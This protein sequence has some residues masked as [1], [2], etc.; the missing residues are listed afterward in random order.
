MR[1]IARSDIVAV[2]LR[3]LLLLHLSDSLS[4]NR[5]T[6][7]ALAKALL[8]VPERSESIFETISPVY[9]GF[10][11]VWVCQ[12]NLVLSDLPSSSSSYKPCSVRLAG[13]QLKSCLANLAS[14]LEPQQLDTAE[15]VIDKPVSAIGQS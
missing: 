5:C 6:Q 9:Q 8:Q 1:R 13:N 3:G 4:T 14:C 15:Q 11:K 7:E 2:L 12:K 10:L